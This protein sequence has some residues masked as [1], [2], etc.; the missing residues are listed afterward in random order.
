M[1][2]FVVEAEETARRE[3]ETA[4]C[5]CELCGEGVKQRGVRA[6]RQSRLVREDESAAV[7]GGAHASLSAYLAAQIQDAQAVC[8]VENLALT[9]ESCEGIRH[10][11]FP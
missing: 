5:E 3:R 7:V 6:A 10:T 11:I 1:R 2:P 9:K 8:T 4:V